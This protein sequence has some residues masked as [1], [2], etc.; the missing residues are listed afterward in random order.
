MISRGRLDAVRNWPLQGLIPGAAFFISAEIHHQ[1]ELWTQLREQGVEKIEEVKEVY[2]E[3]DG[4]FS[5]GRN[6]KSQ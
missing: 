1:D 3:S 6:D 5:V 2:L 4:R